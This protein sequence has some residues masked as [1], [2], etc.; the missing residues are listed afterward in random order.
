MFS[1]LNPPSRSRSESGRRERAGKRRNG[2][3][4]ART[5]HPRPRVARLQRGGP[6]ARTHARTSSGEAGTSGAGAERCSPPLRARGLARRA[7]RRL[8]SPLR[9][10]AVD[11]ELSLPRGGCELGRGGGGRRAGKRLELV[12]VPPA[13]PGRRR[14]QRQ[15]RLHG[16]LICTVERQGLR[17]PSLKLWDLLS[18]G[19]LGWGPC[20]GA[21]TTHG[22]PPQLRCPSQFLTTTCGCGTSLFHIS[23]PLTSLDVASSVCPSLWDLCSA[24]RQVILNNDPSVLQL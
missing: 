13:S 15:A 7:P 20:C 19:T 24:R 9:L 10:Q 5:R 14:P 6:C 18:A 4:R 3:E 2:R 12:P 22:G 17:G 8:G 16:N 11:V 1:S 21:G 23:A